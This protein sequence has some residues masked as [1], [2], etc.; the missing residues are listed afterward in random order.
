MKAKKHVEW[1]L[2]LVIAALAFFCYAQTG[3]RDLTWAHDGADGGDL[4]AAALTGGVPH[5]SGY[6][7]YCL[8]GRLFALLPCGSPARRLTLFSAAAAAASAALLFT[9]VQRLLAQSTAAPRTRMRISAL[10]ALAWAA[11]QTL[12]SQATIIEVYALAALATVLVLW[13]AA[14]IQPSSGLAAWFA[15]GCAW[16]LAVGAHLTLLLLLPTL[17]IV[18][19]PSRSRRGVFGLAAGAAVGLAAFAYL[20]LAAA[21]DPPVNWGAASTWSGFWWLV[22]GKPYRAYLFALPWSALPSR[23]GAWLQLWAHQFTPFGLALALLGL[24]TMPERGAGRWAAATCLLWAA[25]AAYALGYDTTD[26]Y[27]YL[28]PGYLMTAIWLAYGAMTVAEEG[29]RGS[30]RRQLA[31]TAVLVL[32]AA[33]PIWTGWH[34]YHA[35][36]LS[37]EREAVVWV[38]ALDSAL[39]PDTLLITGQDRHTFALQYVQLLTGWRPDMLVVD[40]E[41]LR[42]PWYR[43]Q[44]DLWS[45]AAGQTKGAMP[46]ECDPPPDSLIAL[47]LSQV[48]RRPVYLASERPELAPCLH[49]VPEGIVWRVSALPVDA[50]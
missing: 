17:L 28:L 13:L 3:A 6:P 1:L 24:W 26:S 4:A 39:P 50:E 37:Q 46:H 14:R 40:G 9:L 2:A 44:L 16:G 49:S 25:T 7:T 48:A 30:A 47:A 32:L 19:W 35:L 34:N 36:D 11:G 45:P 20:P 12:W 38:A 31:G 15:L 21:A 8:L 42:Y 23:I 18:V 41:L 22:S 27:V 29:L 10:V 5:P 33:I 43:R